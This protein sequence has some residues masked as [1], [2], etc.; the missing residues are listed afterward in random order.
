V[1]KLDEVLL[2]ELL[3]KFGVPVETWGIGKAQ[4]VGTLLK[5]INEGETHLDENDGRRLT[6]VI[7]IVKMHVKDL[8]HPERGRLVEW[9]QIFPDGRE[10][11]RNNEPSEKTK[12]GEIPAAALVRG[13]REELE[14]DPNEWIITSAPASPV[15]EENE[16]PSYPGL[17]TVY[18]IHHF[19]VGLNS[20]SSAL[21]N[22]F[23]VTDPEGYTS[24]FRWDPKLVG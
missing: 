3:Q 14:Q 13:M 6:R 8:A 22:E 5:E 17:K 20:G 10:R 16:S 9:K 2:R 21:R 23:R 12:A 11:V 24:I 1:K 15:V 4:T 19:C 18:K 7:E